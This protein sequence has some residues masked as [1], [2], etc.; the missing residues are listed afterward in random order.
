MT[1]Q[2]M[3]LVGAGALVGGYLLLRPRGA[4]AATLSQDFNG[5]P[6]GTVMA[7]PGMTTIGDEIARARATLGARAVASN[8]TAG[9]VSFV[10]KALSAANAKNAQAMG[11]IGEKVLPGSGQIFQAVGSVVGKSTTSLLEKGGSAAAKAISKLKF[12]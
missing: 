5:L 8:G 6:L 1:T 11:A 7:K 3:V 4:A 12:W 9:A 2:T 10:N